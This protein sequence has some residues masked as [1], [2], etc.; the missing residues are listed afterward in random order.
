MNTS[1]SGLSTKKIV[2]RRIPA[3][4]VGI[5]N[6][7]DRQAEWGHADLIIAAA[8][9]QPF[10][11]RSTTERVV[12]FAFALLTLWRLPEPSCWAIWMSDIG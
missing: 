2:G 5:P 1:T 10:F 11:P 4:V 8:T 3:A 12:E 6:M 9:L 7:L